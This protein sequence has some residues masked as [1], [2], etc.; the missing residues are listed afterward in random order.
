VIGG[1]RGIPVL[2]R[3]EACASMGEETDGRNIPRA[4][5]TLI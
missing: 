3:L 4:L 5:A 2:G 1:G